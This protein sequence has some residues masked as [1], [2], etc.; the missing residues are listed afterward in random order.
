MTNQS[1]LV[2]SVIVISLLFIQTFSFAQQTRRRQVLSIAPRVGV[3]ISD[4]NGD[5]ANN[6]I[7][8]G[9]SGGAMLTYSVVNTFGISVEALYSQKG[10]KFE[11]AAYGSERMN[12]N[13]RINYIEVPV[14][15]RYFLNKN[16]DFR[17]NLFIGP[18]FG[19]K[20]SA[21]DANREL[22][23]GTARPDVDISN[24]INPVDVGITGGIGLNFSVIE[25]MRFLIDAR[26]TYGLTDISSAPLASFTG[27]QDVKNSAIT[28][29]FG[30]SFGIGKKYVK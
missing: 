27:G 1:K 21:K 8:L 19:F 14:L 24:A 22:T 6:N 13:R 28:L 16:G 29:T 25:S 30:V 17:P 7:Q 4:F 5:V 20:L 23:S 3:N 18:D 10:A 26:Y 11:N 12:F 9:F 15:A 2:V